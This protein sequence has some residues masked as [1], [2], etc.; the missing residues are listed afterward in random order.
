[1]SPLAG[2]VLGAVPGPVSVPGRFLSRFSGG[3]F[4][5]RMGELLNTQKNVHFLP[6]GPSRGPPGGPPGAPPD[7]P[8]SILY[9][10]ST[11][12]GWGRFSG[13]ARGPP[14]G[15]PGRP[16][17]RARPRAPGREIFPPGG[18]PREGPP[19]GPPGGGPGTR[20]AGAA[21]GW[22][23]AMSWMRYAHGGLLPLRGNAWQWTPNVMV[24]AC[25]AV[26]STSSC[27]SASSSQ[28]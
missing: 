2:A 6:P 4:L 5:S 11:P 25:S 15:A 21:S 27:M 1:M 14:G 13:S 22:W 12:L 28:R 7:T 24:H 26:A 17:A 9:F 18:G 3:I 16:G 20:G 8:I 23:G 10:S 19:E